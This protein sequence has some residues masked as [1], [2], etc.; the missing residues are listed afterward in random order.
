[1]RADHPSNRKRG[2]VC[3]SYKNHL[4]IIKRNDSYQLHEC[5]VTELRIGK[6]K[7]FFTCLYRSPS[8]ISE[9]HEDFCADL[10][11]RLSN[12]N[13]LNATCCVITGDFNARSPKWWALDKENNEGREISFLTSSA[14]YS[15]LIDQPTHITKESSSCIDLIFTSN[16]SF[17]SASGVKLSLYEKC[18]HNL[19]Y[20]KINFKV[21]LPP[22]Y[23]REVW[24]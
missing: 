4:P 1:M 22:P 5:L 21:P 19:I 7:Y 20:G 16:R 9:E 13:D 10:N 18:H 12:I 11:L 17:F 3:I 15:Q 24:D 14:G 2:G 6:K 8:Q 23:E